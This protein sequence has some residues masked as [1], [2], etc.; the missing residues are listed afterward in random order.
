MVQSCRLS[1][2]LHFLSY[3]T[4]KIWCI[5]LLKKNSR[6]HFGLSVVIKTF[7]CWPPSIRLLKLRS[8]A[9]LTQRGPTAI[10]RNDATLH[11]ESWRWLTS[12]KHAGGH[13]AK[14]KHKKCLRKSL[15]NLTFGSAML[16]NGLTLNESACWM[17][18]CKW[19]LSL[20]RLL[21][22]CYCTLYFDLVY[23]Y[24][25]NAVGF[26]RSKCVIKRSCL[27]FFPSGQTLR[28]CSIVAY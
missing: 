13:C 27:L 23:Y 4:P 3:L 6:S 25:F 19:T 9:V 21:A 20:F 22:V 7:W 5:F 16:L 15:Q 11:K 18:E 2:Y 24:W 26:S 14:Y 17:R 28:S 1:S 10:Q 8:H 12:Y